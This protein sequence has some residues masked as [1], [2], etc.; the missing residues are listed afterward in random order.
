MPRFLL[1][2]AALL[3]LAPS[4]SAETISTWSI[5]GSGSW[6]SAANWSPSNIP[7]DQ[8]GVEES[9]FFNAGNTPQVSL[10]TNYQVTPKRIVVDDGRVTLKSTS[11]FTSAQVAVEELTLESDSRL[12]ANDLVQL[13][14]DQVVISGG[15]IGDSNLTFVGG[16]TGL[17]GSVSFGP[18][19]GTARDGLMDILP[20]AVVDLDELTMAPN[21]YTAQVQVLGGTLRQ[22][23]NQPV[24]VGVS[25]GGDAVITITE[26]TLQFAGPVV[27]EGT[28]RI[29]NRGGSIDF[30]QSLELR[31]QGTSY[32]ERTG[33]S[34]EREFEAGARLS[35]LDGAS[36]TFQG[37]ALELDDGQTLEIE[38]AESASLTTEGGLILGQTSLAR[39][40]I[41]G[42]TATPAFVQ[43]DSTIT[44][45]GELHVELVAGASAPTAG[46]Q[47]TLFAADG[48][49]SGAFASMQ[50]PQIAGIS[51]EFQATANALTLIA[52]E[53]IPG[54]YNSD[55]FVDAAD[56]TVWRDSLATSSPVGSYAD[57]RDN[58]GNSLAGGNSSAVPEPSA[59]C[60]LALLAPFL[61]RRCR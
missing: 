41:D 50:A 57:W 43:S 32:I 44:L 42:A 52:H 29:S 60:L 56:Y 23:S 25:G 34:A 33:T 59:S 20:S 5:V 24:Q 9:A 61:F 35:L 18:G 30:A 13:S 36:A 49:L 48:G 54:D 11:S 19:G 27:V 37:A 26:G 39:L 2:V 22:L 3:S 15:G 51:W 53:A 47:A 45:A 4:A 21:D 46:Y 6:D 8:A 17:L 1:A 28:G 31:G 58:F 10:P 14:A 12:I 40:L 38:S 16:S 7:G 55:G